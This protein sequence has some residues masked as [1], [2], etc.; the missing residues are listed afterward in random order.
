[1]K[2]IVTK[3]FFLILSTLI[4][5]SKSKIL[6]I[7]ETKDKNPIPFTGFKINREYKITGS[8]HPMNMNFLSISHCNH[9]K[10]DYEKV[11]KIENSTHIDWSRPFCF[12]K[13]QIKGSVKK[14]SESNIRSLMIEATNT[15][16]QLL[17]HTD[18]QKNTDDSFGKNSD[19]SEHLEEEKGLLKKTKI[20]MKQL[21]KIFRNVIDKKIEHFTQGKYVQ[22][23]GVNIN[24]HLTDIQDSD[25][26]SSLEWESKNLV[27]FKMARK[28]KYAKRN[29][30]FFMP[31]TFVGGL[32]E[33]FVSAEKR[34]S[35]FQKFTTDTFVKSFDFKCDNS[36][37]LPI[38]PLIADDVTGQWFEF[39]FDSFL[40]PYFLQTIPFLTTATFLNLRF[41]PSETPDMFKDT[42][43]TQVDVNEDY[44][45][46]DIDLHLISKAIAYS[47]NYLNKIIS[48]IDFNSLL[49]S[50]NFG[51]NKLFKFNKS[52]KIFHKWINYFSKEQKFSFLFSYNNTKNDK[53]SL[54]G[55][56]H[57]KNINKIWNDLLHQFDD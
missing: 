4:H 47:S 21:K 24:N 2:L 53:D 31:E 12:L 11:I 27:C 35:I 23:T 34:K 5:N 17:N 22:Y 30:S 10:V 6:R 43:A 36:V 51:F 39:K 1:M 50:K 57:L 18:K 38:L 3:R 45:Y 7:C 56:M 14:K 16:S 32:F 37:S 15:Q 54:N 52:N 49:Y 8:L 33:C 13:P 46:N 29:I 9:G 20:T 28:K 48:P 41:S 42:W 25:P 26:Q 19:V 40:R 55:M 44:D